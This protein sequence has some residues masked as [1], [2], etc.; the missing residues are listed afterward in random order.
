MTKCRLLNNRYK[1]EKMLGHGGMG[2][3][4]L[5]TDI[6]TQQ[7]VAVKEC[8]C[9][10]ENNA[11]ERI[12]REYYFMTKI[13]HPYLV[14]GVDF[15][16]IQD[17]Y[18]IVMEYVDGIT[19]G[20]F[21]RKH[22]HSIS[23]NQ[24]LQIAIHI[25]DAV[26]TLNKNG[27]IHRDIKP[28]NIILTQPSWEPKLLD[29]GIAKAI[30]GELVTITKTENIIGT[31]DYMAPEQIDPRIEMR[32]NLDVFSLGIVFYQFFAWLPESPFATGQIVSTLDRIMRCELPALFS[33]QTHQKQQHISRVIQQALCKDPRERIESVATLQ[34]LLCSDTLQIQIAPKRSNHLKQIKSSSKVVSW[35]AQRLRMIFLLLVN[36]ILIFLFASGESESQVLFLKEPLSSLYNSNN[37]HLLEYY[38][39]EIK[40]H[41]GARQK[42]AYIERSRIFY[43]MRQLEENYMP[44]ALEDAAKVDNITRRLFLLHIQT[45]ELIEKAKVRDHEFVKKLAAENLE[46][47]LWLKKRRQRI[48]FKDQRLFYGAERVAIH[49]LQDTRRS[50]LVDTGYGDLYL[51][52]TSPY[53][54]K[55]I[56]FLHKAQL[57]IANEERVYLEL[58]DTYI[59]LGF[60][61]KADEVYGILK[62]MNEFLVE[63]DF[64][65]AKKHL[66]VGDFHKVK[67]TFAK[68]ENNF[69]Q[70]QTP[71]VQVL[72]SKYLI[73]IKQEELA[74]RII[75]GLSTKNLSAKDQVI[76]QRLQ[77]Y[78]NSSIVFWG[79]YLILAET[80]IELGL[81]AEAQKFLDKAHEL[82]TN[83]AESHTRKDYKRLE[84]LF[85]L[86]KLQLLTQKVMTSNSINEQTMAEIKRKVKAIVDVGKQIEIYKILTVAHFRIWCLQ[87]NIANIPE[88]DEKIL[89][90]LTGDYF[91][92]H[93][94]AR[95]YYYQKQYAMA[96]VYWERANYM[97]P[98]IYFTSMQKRAFAKREESKNNEVRYVE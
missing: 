81:F 79:Q 51:A 15:F 26:A 91:F 42:R 70:R 30:N 22:P 77:D 6:H 14:Q 64:V 17:R 73:A 12:K 5:M 33:A 59:E 83:D 44:R 2:R 67:D 66:A 78:Y 94:K 8:F 13:Q 55:R 31:P 9:P 27:V 56:F 62:D 86:L 20:D 11:V 35:L 40:M 60:F 25:C 88:L 36:C 84:G 16:Q 95:D 65:M 76:V 68:W 34:K 57:L 54:G 71:W 52:C 38:N 98:S 10:Q 4:Y 23:L 58:L 61:D 93:V 47:C 82:L 45:L 37:V 19:L 96:I 3:V 92:F 49:C 75:K 21:I 63:T 18:F 97:I 69:W 7:R 74:G 41:D 39:H 87:N 1:P 50:F 53:V 28:E 24:Q 29:F 46:L 89:R 48:N 85:G 43:Q 80:W 90:N 32:G 72:R